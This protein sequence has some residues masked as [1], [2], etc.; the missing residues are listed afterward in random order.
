MSVEGEICRYGMQKMNIG[1]LSKRSGLS[2]SRIRFYEQSGL[3][4]AAERGLNGYR[5]YPAEMVQMLELVTMAQSVGFSLE[6]I[7]ALL[8]AGLNDWNH[9]LVVDALRQKISDVEALQKKLRQSKKQLNA[10]LS[11]IEAR[12]DVMDCRDNAQR[13]MALA[14][15]QESSA[16]IEESAAH[17]KVGK[18]MRN[19]HRKPSAS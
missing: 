3:L 4:E 18:L 10:L 8:P 6:E 12:P 19:A 1:E 13:I 15:S 7:R 2:T 16:P 11:Q 14:L 9:D 17:E 5:S